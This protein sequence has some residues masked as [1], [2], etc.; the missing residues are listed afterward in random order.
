MADWCRY[1]GYPITPT[2]HDFPCQ[3]MTPALD[4]VMEAKANLGSA[5]TTD[6]HSKAFAA[7][8]D[9]LCGHVGNLERGA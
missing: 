3:P 7:C 9:G 5:P 1:C 6:Q 4:G 8:R 2:T